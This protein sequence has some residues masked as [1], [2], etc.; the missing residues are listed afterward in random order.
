M[1]QVCQKSVRGGLSTA[2]VIALLAATWASPTFAF[3][4][5][6]KEGPPPVEAPKPVIKKD[7]S[8]Y[9]WPSPPAITRLKYLDYFAAEKPPVEEEKKVEKKKGWMDRLAGVDQQAADKKAG[10]GPLFQLMTPYGL[11]VDSKGMLYVADTKVGA[12]FVV[13]PETGDTS[14]IKHGLDA[15]FGEMFGLAIDDADRLFVSDGKFN[16]VLVFNAQHKLEGQF[17]EGVMN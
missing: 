5:K 15:K 2:V 14:F 6:E 11:A 13:N 12:I 8:G 7:L 10:R 1:F 17:G 16:H 3:E 9:V 4:K